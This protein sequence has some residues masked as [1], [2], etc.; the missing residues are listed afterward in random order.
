MLAREPEEVA[1]FLAKTQ[2][3]NKTMIGEYL[4]EREDN[5]LRVMH[6]Y[7]DAMD[8][9]GA[10]F[11]Q[12]I[13]YDTCHAH[14]GMKICAITGLSPVSEWGSVL[15]VR[16]TA[17]ALH[18]HCYCMKV[19]RRTLLGCRTQHSSTEN[20]QLALCLMNVLLAG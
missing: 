19:L 14:A 6:A 17:V 8:F 2:G 18:H 13:R 7:V 15:C 1:R 20:G 16:G 5:C 11:D 12:A 4:G 10:A 9:S 3:L